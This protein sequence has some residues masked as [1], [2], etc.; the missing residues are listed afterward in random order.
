MKILKY[1]LF[2]LLLSF[3]LYGEPKF[4]NNA[5]STIADA[6]G[7]SNVDTTLNVAAGEGAEF[8]TV[9]APNYFM[10]TLADTSGNREIVKVTARATDTFTIVRAQEGTAARAWSQGDIVS[11]RLTAGVLD[12]LASRIGSNTAYLSDYASLSAAVTDIGATETE[13]WIDTDDTMA[14]NV[15]TPATLRL[16]F[17]EGNTI[18]PDGNTLTIDSPHH[19]LASCTQQI[20]SGDTV[21][22]T[23]ASGNTICVEWWGTDDDA[24]Q[25]ALTCANASAGSLQAESYGTTED[26]DI[27]HVRVLLST[28][29]NIE[30][31]ITQPSKT[32]FDMANGASLIRNYNGDLWKINDNFTQIGTIQFDASDY[33]SALA[34]DSTA[35]LVINTSSGLYNDMPIQA[36]KAYGNRY[37][38]G[39]KVRG[40]VV[41]FDAD[42]SGTD[43]VYYNQWRNIT[44]GYFK[45]LFY[46]NMSADGAGNA[47]VKGNVFGP[48]DINRIRYLWYDNVTGTQG[49]LIYNNYFGPISYEGGNDAACLPAAGTGLFNFDAT[50]SEV[51]GNTFYGIYDDFNAGQLFNGLEGATSQN[52][53]FVGHI[54]ETYVGEFNGAIHWLDSPLPNNLFTIV[55]GAEN[56]A[57]DTAGQDLYPIGIQGTAERETVPFDCY[58]YAIGMYTSGGAANA[59]TVRL[60][61]TEFGL[62]HT[63]TLTLGTQEYYTVFDYSTAVATYDLAAGDG[64]RL[65][66]T[67]ASLG[68]ATEDIRVRLYMV[69]Q[70]NH[71]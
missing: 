9:S 51:E 66:A 65:K 7:I 24:I 34:G 6:G 53:A 23:L 16:R 52:V 55:F 46:W 61:S 22:F 1:T 47:G 37:T 10:V 71:L 11:H 31:L 3:S 2:L 14:G 67:T 59:S 50:N 48:M 62:D 27:S 8:P 29:V 60:Y 64:F 43:D 57:D 35:C 42:A 21:E 69:P 56:L 13:L 63:F 45:Y 70:K 15:T 36:L 26:T 44:A 38:A 49:S 12:V 58:V 68:L 4:T 19:I 17:V 33:T 18:D 25:A 20:F 5:S 39:D 30:A 40:A 41:R 54:V 28:D 32:L